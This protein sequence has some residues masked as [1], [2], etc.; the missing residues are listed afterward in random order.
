MRYRKW[1]D[2]EIERLKAMIAAGASATRIAV[3]LRRPIESVYDRARR[4]GLRLPTRTEE[5]RRAR[6][7]LA[8]A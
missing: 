2:E 6:N 3:A 7:L 8:P 1:T 4:L 5:R